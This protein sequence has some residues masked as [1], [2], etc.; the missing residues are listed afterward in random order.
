MIDLSGNY[1]ISGG[2]ETVL[3]LWQ[4][5]TGR[6]QTLPHL[7]API[8]SIVVSP[9]GSSYAIRLADNSAMI[10]STTELEP[11]FN[12]SGIQVPAPNR[13]TLKIP[14]IP[15]LSSYNKTPPIFRKP[16]A[17]TSSVGPSR[18]ILAVPAASFSRTGRSHSLAANYL[19]TY[20]PKSGSHIAKQA[21]ARTKA[22]ELNMGPEGNNI[23]E[24]CVVLLQITNDGKWLAT[25]DEW[26]SPQRDFDPISVDADAA[27]AEQQCRKE[28][29][30]KFWSRSKDSKSWELSSRIDDPHGITSNVQRSS[31]NVLD[32]TEDPSSSGFAT[33]GNEGII[34]IWKPKVRLRDGISVRDPDGRDLITWSCL[35]AIS[36][37]NSMNLG[38]NNSSDLHGR[39]AFSLDG[40]LLIAGFSSER[41]S[42]IHMIDTVAGHIKFSRQD[43]F[44]GPLI[45]LGVLDRF[46]ILLSHDLIVWDLVDNQINYGIALQPYELKKQD[47]LATSHLAIDRINKTFAIARLEKSKTHEKIKTQTRVA[48]FEP[49]QPKSLFKTKLRHSLKV[50]LPASQSQSYIAVDT[51]AEIHAIESVISLPE[52]FSEEEIEEQEQPTIPQRTNNNIN[53]L[54]AIESKRAVGSE[55][56]G[57]ETSDDEQRLLIEEEIPVVIRQHQLAE[58]FDVSHPFMLPAVEDMFEQVA[59]LFSQI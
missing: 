2:L 29:Y 38:A 43:L 34:K 42:V 39:V 16:A 59:E 13:P 11:S 37:P 56:L 3:A 18:L 45:G 20:D 54:L 32:L 12:V 8:E 7:Q 35:H 30:L 53:D 28:T 10:L 9:S 26:I 49:Y 48:I 31:G 50:L 14:E 58:I 40:S 6:K 24:P 44:S 46:L 1:V 51:T 52:G 55:L 22:T 27:I 21:L 57:A 4:V 23:E 19:Q 36:L 25:V 5:D 15:F 33:V 47:L 41:S 17:T